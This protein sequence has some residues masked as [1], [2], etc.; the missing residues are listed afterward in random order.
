MTKAK[1]SKTSPDPFKFSAIGYV[2]SPFK[3]RYAVPRQHGFAQ[4][5][6]GV[7]KLNS[8]PNLKLALSGLEE[9][10][11]IWVLFVFH[12][13]GGKS[14]KHTVRPPRFNG[15][16]KM[17][18]FATRSPHRPNPIGISTMRLEKI[19]LKAKS[20]P[21]LHV[22]GIDLIDE[23][24]VL[25]IKPY[26]STADSIPDAR[27]GWADE[28]LK[29]VP[30]TFEKDVEK[31]IDPDLRD[32]LIGI[33]ELDPRSSNQK[34]R[35]PLDDPEQSGREYGF[36]LKNAEVTYQIRNGGF[37]VLAVTVNS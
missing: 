4:S 3:D 14:W 25:D 30:V 33:I 20:G 19:D 22:S 16:R 18:L 21:E 15:E 27:L 12:A 24:P 13:H 36:T 37:H 2:Q 29:R 8:D 6:K 35:A 1:K 23:T 5:V 26:I 11:H 31:S 32:M 17:G 34:I 28:P 10:S 9:F 7:I